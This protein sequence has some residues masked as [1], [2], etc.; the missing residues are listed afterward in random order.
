YKLYKEEGNWE[1]FWGMAEGGNGLEGKLLA[2]DGENIWAP[3]PGLYVADVSLSG[4]TYKLTLVNTVH[5]TG[6]NDDWSLTPMTATDVPGVYTATVTKSANTPW[7]VKAV[8]NENWD[9]A[10]GGGGGVLRLHQ[11][12]FDGD[13]DLEN[14][15]YTLTVNLCEGTYSYSK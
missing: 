9:I 10:F 3:D 1:E 8:I 13:N 2:N 6:L 4:L 5:Y 15:T 11:D 7:G 12:G 14:G